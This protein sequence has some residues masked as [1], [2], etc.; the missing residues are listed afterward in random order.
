SERNGSRNL[1]F[2]ARA[3]NIRVKL[4]LFL[5][6]REKWKSQLTFP[7]ECKKYKSETAF[8]SGKNPNV[9]NMIFDI[10]TFGHFI[11]N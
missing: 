4:L 8:V 5:N 3:R 1:H 10:Q 2:R 7:S 6:E 9:K 11:G